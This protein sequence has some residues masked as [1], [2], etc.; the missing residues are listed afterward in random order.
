MVLFIALRARKEPEGV[1]MKAQLSP[2]GKGFDDTRRAFVALKLMDENRLEDAAAA[3]QPL[4]SRSPLRLSA[5]IENVRG[6]AAEAR[7]E[8]AGLIDE[9]LLEQAASGAH[10]FPSQKTPTLVLDFIAEVA[11]YYEALPPPRQ[12][13]A[14]TAETLDTMF[15]RASIERKL[16]LL[17]TPAHRRGGQ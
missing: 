1:H 5:L 10:A 15:K 8:L 4:L 14:A 12:R 13:G 9:W 6:G 7:E 16:R 2:V 3:L 17:E 11:A